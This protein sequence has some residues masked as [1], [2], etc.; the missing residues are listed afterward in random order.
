MFNKPN[1][2]YVFNHLEITIEYHSGRNEEWGA[3]FLDQ[4]SF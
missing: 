3:G 4:V 1:S 2:F